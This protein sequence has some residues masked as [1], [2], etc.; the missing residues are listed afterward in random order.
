MRVELR[1][2]SAGDDQGRCFIF[3]QIR[4]YLNDRVLNLLRQIEFCVPGNRGLRVPLRRCRL[5][6]NAGR[7][8]GPDLDFIDESEP[9]LRTTSFHPGSS[10]RQSPCARRMLYYCIKL[11]NTGPAG[12]LGAYPPSALRTPPS[13]GSVAMFRAAWQAAERMPL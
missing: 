12:T 7:V 6:V 4:H 5:G 13:D 8:A 3:D 1:D 10:R 11:R 9:E 2:E